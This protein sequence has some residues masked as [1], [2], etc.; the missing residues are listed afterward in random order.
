MRKLA[1]AVGLSILSA[2]LGCTN[3]PHTKPAV[4]QFEYKHAEWFSLESNLLSSLGDEGWEMCGV[5][6]VSSGLE[7]TV[8][9]F[10]RPKQ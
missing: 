1:F 3:Q 7:R 8:V 5:I 4:Q 9:I 6:P 10:K 2:V